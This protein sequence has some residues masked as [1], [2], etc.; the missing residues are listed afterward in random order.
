MSHYH[1]NIPVHSDEIKVMKG[2]F[3]ELLKNGFSLIV[4]FEDNEGKEEHI[5]VELQDTVRRLFIRLLARL[6]QGN[7]E[8]LH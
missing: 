4:T 1:I 5:S 8:A 2:R 6:I 3:E 7:F